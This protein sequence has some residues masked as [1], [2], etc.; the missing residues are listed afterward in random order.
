MALY[1]F[2][3]PGHID[4][5]LEEGL[6]KGH[7]PVRLDPPKLLEGWQWLTEDGSFDQSWNTMENL[8]YDRTAYRITIR[9]PPLANNKLYRWTSV[10]DRLVE[11][12]A[13]RSLNAKGDPENWVLFKGVLRPRWFV[14]VTAKEGYPSRTL[15]EQSGGE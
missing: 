13:R 1:H 12:Q 5:C 11:P 8:D 6:T 9:V 2:T 3:S 7:V 15:D 14:G 10:M 4:G